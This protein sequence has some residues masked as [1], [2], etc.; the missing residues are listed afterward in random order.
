M[1]IFTGPID[2]FFGYKY[3]KLKYRGQNRSIE[4]LR[5]I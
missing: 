5:I 3:G 2:E 1:V 4:H